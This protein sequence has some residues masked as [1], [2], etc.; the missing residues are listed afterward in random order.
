MDHSTVNDQ[1]YRQTA[2]ETVEQQSKIA[3]QNI[4]LYIRSGN[5]SLNKNTSHDRSAIQLYY[6]VSDTEKCQAM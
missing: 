5:V 1:G 6:Q 4:S 3:V 2:V